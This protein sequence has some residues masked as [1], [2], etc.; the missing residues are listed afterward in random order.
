MGG[1][2]GGLIACA[3]LIASD[4]LLTFADLAIAEAGET[5]HPSVSARLAVLVYRQDLA[6]AMIGI[7]LTGLVLGLAFH[8]A[9]PGGRSRRRLTVAGIV[10]AGLSGLAIGGA[11]ATAGFAAFGMQHVGDQDLIVASVIN[12]SVWAAL[13]LAAGVAAY[14]RL[15]DRPARRAALGPGLVGGLLWGLLYSPLVALIFP[16]A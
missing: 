11:A 14:T 9:A 4:G 13:G 16:W 12:G 3:A 2:L 6:N 15:P 10:A 8:L 7:G 5:P 1:A